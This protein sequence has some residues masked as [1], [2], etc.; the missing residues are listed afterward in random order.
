MNTGLWEADCQGP[1]SILARDWLFTGC[2]LSEGN[3][4]RGGRR[5]EALGH[6]G[7]RYELLKANE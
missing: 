5:S 3:T 4:L 7:L 1:Q 2:D 6:H